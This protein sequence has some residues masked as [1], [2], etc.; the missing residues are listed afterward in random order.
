MRDHI[1][2]SQPT[3]VIK[4]GFPALATLDSSDH[5]KHILLISIPHLQDVFN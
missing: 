2:N 4:S 5:M 1:I 3:L